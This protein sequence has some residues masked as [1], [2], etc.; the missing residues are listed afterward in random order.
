MAPPELTAEFLLKM[1][2]L[3][4]GWLALYLLY[5]PPPS[6]AVLL[7]NIQLV[8][9]GLPE[10][11]HIPPPDVAEF[12]KKVQSIRTGLLLALN[13]PPPRVAELLLKIQFFIVGLLYEQ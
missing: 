8:S 10:E 11:F 9:C 2:F 7:S 5:I 1:Q 3:I 4:T 12:S 13:I 6:F